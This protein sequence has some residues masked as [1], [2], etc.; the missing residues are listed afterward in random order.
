MSTL[1]LAILIVDD[2]QG[3]REMIKTIIQDLA[4]E[5]F[6]ARSGEE[7]VRMYR[8]HRPDLVLM[9]L[10]MRTMGGLEATRLITLEFPEAR[11]VIVTNHDQSV[12][13]EAARTAGACG[14]VLKDDLLAVR[15]LINQ[16]GRAKP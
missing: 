4:R 11:I 8:M 14:Y 6:E 1:P 7:G 9:D 10:F 5:L 2:H 15:E 3:I 13:R 16:I 12:L